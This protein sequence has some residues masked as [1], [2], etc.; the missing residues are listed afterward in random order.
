MWDFISTSTQKQQLQV[1]RFLFV[2]DVC[3]CQGCYLDEILGGSFQLAPNFESKNSSKI[4][5]GFPPSARWVKNPWVE[6]SALKIEHGGRENGRCNVPKKVGAANGSWSW[7]ISNFVALKKMKGTTK[8]KGFVS[9]SKL[10]FFLN[11]FFFV[12][13]G[14]E[15]F[16]LR[17]CT[18][19]HDEI[20]AQ[21]KPNWQVW[22]ETQKRRA[23][24]ERKK[25]PPGGRGSGGL[26]CCGSIDEW[27]SWR[28]TDILRSTTTSIQ[29]FLDEGSFWTPKSCFFGMSQGAKN[30]IDF[31]QIDH[32]EESS[33]FVAIFEAF[34]SFCLFN[35]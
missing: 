21:R 26:L 2:T 7:W 35:G 33:I 34:W 22:C 20:L 17:D 11:S 18:M 1:I 12:F 27:I 16:V 5:S 10:F 29:Q 8:R 24:R 19:I 30:L 31:F 32:F 6:P 14:S 28:R 25:R 4:S 3:C 13:W 9:V 23:E 15:V